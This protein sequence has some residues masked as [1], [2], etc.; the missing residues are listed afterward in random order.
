[1]KWVNKF[2]LL[3]SRL[4][5]EA[6]RV[7]SGCCRPKSTMATWS[8]YAL[9]DAGVAGEQR[10]SARFSLTPAKDEQKA[11]QVESGGKKKAAP[12]L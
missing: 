7:I 2:W 12:R 3:G 9:L 11:S 1:M 5:R 8:W 4:H 10:G 6:T